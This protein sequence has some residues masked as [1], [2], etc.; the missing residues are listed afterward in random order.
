MLEKINFRN[1]VILSSSTLNEVQKGTT[2]NPRLPRDNYYGLPTAANDSIWYISER[3]GIKD[4]ELADPDIETQSNIG[5]LAYD[6]VI[7]GCQNCD[8]ESLEEETTFLEI[9][10]GPP[11]VTYRDIDG[12]LLPSGSDDSRSIAVFVNSGSYLNDQG[13]RTSWGLSTV[14]VDEGTNY[15]YFDI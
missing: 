13:Q 1:G 11:R 6:G 12:S 4:W 3:D 8:I 2:F 14:I 10:Y 15:I 9:Q 7:L 5:R